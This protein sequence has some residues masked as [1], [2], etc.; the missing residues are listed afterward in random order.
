MRALTRSITIP[1]TWC[2]ATGAVH[3]WRCFEVVNRLVED[4][5]DAVG[6]SFN[7]MHVAGNLGTPTT[8][9]RLETPTPTRLGETLAAS[10]RLVHLG[11]SSLAFEVT[12]E[13]AGKPRLRAATTLVWV[14]NDHG[15]LRSTPMPA[16]LR[17]RM[18]EWLPDAAANAQAGENGA[19]P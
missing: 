16:D 6:F 19:T 1:G 13:H 14:S 4:W 17:A 12:A 7:D 8:Q 2:D 3:Q 15:R 9:L 10:L 11:R 18:A 5:F